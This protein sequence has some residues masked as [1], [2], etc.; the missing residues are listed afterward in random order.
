LT[1]DEGTEGGWEGGAEPTEL[2]RNCLRAGRDRS[3]HT[4]NGIES[5][6][7]HPSILLPIFTHPTTTLVAIHSIHPELAAP[8]STADQLALPTNPHDRFQ[9]PTH[10]SKYTLVMTIHESNG[11]SLPFLFIFLS[12][13]SNVHTSSPSSSSYS[14]TATTT[15]AAF[16]PGSDHPVRQHSTAQSVITSRIG[17]RIKP[18]RKYKSKVRMDGWM[19]RSMIMMASL[20]S[21]FIVSYSFLFFF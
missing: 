15:S 8:L 14:N 17:F 7:T 9:Q 1:N 18:D 12:A 3:K 10:N 13:T 2:D 4:A 11:R 6:F 5:H 16:S 20:S 19:M 21:Y